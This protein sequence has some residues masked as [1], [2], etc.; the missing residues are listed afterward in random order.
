MAMAAGCVRR[1]LGL[2]TCGSGPGSWSPQLSLVRAA[3]LCTAAGDPP[4]APEAP[5]KKSK[6]Q[7]PGAQPSFGSVGRRIPHRTVQLIGESGQDMGVMHRADVLKLLDLQGLKLVLLN[8]SAEPPV[9]RL[10]SGRQI[11][12]EQLKMREKQKERAAPLQVKE[13]VFSSSIAAHDLATKL[14]QVETWLERT[15]QVRLT[16]RCGHPAHKDALDSTLAEM[17]RQLDAAFGFV[18]QPRVVRE[19][20]AAACVLRP[21]TRK[22]LAKRE[23]EKEAPPAGAG[24]TDRPQPQ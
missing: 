13:L 19:G 23:K 3:A 6:K 9:Y 8:A 18:S 20:K 5:G 10:M 12:E 16:L 11:H 7:G 4:E 24:S 17:L 21:P 1:L 22:E 2:T 15:H 14:K